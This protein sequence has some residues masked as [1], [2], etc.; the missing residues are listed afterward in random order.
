M[1]LSSLSHAVD[2]LKSFSVLYNI[3]LNKDFLIITLF[4]FV[5]KTFRSHGEQLQPKVQEMLHPWLHHLL[6]QS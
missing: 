1:E 2:M 4:L 6:N 5:L 3:S